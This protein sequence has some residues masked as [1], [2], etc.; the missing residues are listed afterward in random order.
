LATLVH[1]LAG[2][3]AEQGA[4]A[5]TIRTAREKKKA[6]RN[7]KEKLLANDDKTRERK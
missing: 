4:L 3:Q 7:T 5:G 1:V 2:Q 6:S